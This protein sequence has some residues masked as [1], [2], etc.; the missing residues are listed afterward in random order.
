M[1]DGR[2]VARELEEDVWIVTT[3]E[4]APNVDYVDEAWYDDEWFPCDFTPPKTE[5]PDSQKE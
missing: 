4:R 2:F 1:N 3:K 5:Q